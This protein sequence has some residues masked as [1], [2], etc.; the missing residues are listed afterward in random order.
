MGN[1][2]EI[3]EVIEEAIKEIIARYVAEDKKAECINRDTLY[4]LWLIRKNIHAKEQAFL[5]NLE[6]KSQNKGT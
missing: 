5:Q 2:K 6:D 4:V 1:R 3:N